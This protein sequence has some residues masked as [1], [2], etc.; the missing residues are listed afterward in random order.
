LTPSAQLPAGDSCCVS[1]LAVG[2]G[3]LWIAVRD[4]GTAGSLLRFSETTG[5]LEAQWPVGSSP[6]AIAVATGQVW[7]A[8]GPGDMSVPEVDANTVEELSAASGQVIA[9]YDVV[10]PAAVVALSNGVLVVSMQTPNGPTQI[11]LLQGDGLRL[12]STIDE[13]LASAGA[14]AG[15][16]AACGGQAFVAVQSPS[17]RQPPNVTIERVDLA[18]GAATAIAT[19]PDS[20]EAALACDSIAVY[21]ALGSPDDGGIYR[22]DLADDSIS[23]PWGTSLPAGVVV[24]ADRLWTVGRTDGVGSP[25]YVACLNPQ[26][27]ETCPGQAVL[28]PETAGSYFVAL[29]DQA[30]ALWIVAGGELIEAPIGG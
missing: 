9:T 8:N 17:G 3:S 5:A 10:D 27:G 29:G 13:A 19:V 25:G 7:V 24:S 20:G 30:P 18:S 15:V 11:S 14:S 6:E 21:L 22:V 26:S 12:T 28:P 4:A 2:D 23:G 16:V 1:A